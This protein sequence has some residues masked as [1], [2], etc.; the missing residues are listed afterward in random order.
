MYALIHREL[1]YRMIEKYPKIQLLTVGELQAGKKIEMP[2]V[3][4][5]N[6]TFKKAERH[7]PKDGEQLEIKEGK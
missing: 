1:P 2:P 6:Q 3:R 4:Q 7:R 5:V